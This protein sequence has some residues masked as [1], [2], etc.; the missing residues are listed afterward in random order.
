ME[1]ALRQSDQLERKAEAHREEMPKERRQGVIRSREERRKVDVPPPPGSP[2][3]SGQ[4]RR[5]G[6]R[7]SRGRP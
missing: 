7:R 2:V 6:D 3:R 1:K 4:D 5:A